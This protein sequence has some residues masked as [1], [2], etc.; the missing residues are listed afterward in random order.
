MGVMDPNPNIKSRLGFGRCSSPPPPELDDMDDGLKTELRKIAVGP[1][2]FELKKMIKV[3]NDFNK[4]DLRDS[5]TPERCAAAAENSKKEFYVKAKPIEDKNLRVQIR[6]DE[7]K[8]EKEYKVDKVDLSLRAMKLKSN[9]DQRRE[10][11]SSRSS[12]SLVTVQSAS[13]PRKRLVK[14]ETLKDGTVLRTEI[15]PDDPILDSV[16]IK[17]KKHSDDEVDDDVIHDKKIRM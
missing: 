12:S 5:V 13:N 10:K 16:P 15:D 9:L 2:R 4:V 11:E 3:V 7:Y 14:V 8:E 17:K 1:G 6:N